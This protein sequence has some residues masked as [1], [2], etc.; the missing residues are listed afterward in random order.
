M[1]EISQTVSMYNCSNGDEFAFLCEDARMEKVNKTRS[2]RAF[3]F[4]TRQPADCR[5]VQDDSMIPKVL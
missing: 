3:G 4:R 2:P 5:I 1:R